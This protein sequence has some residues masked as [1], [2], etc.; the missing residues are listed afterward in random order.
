M[1]SAASTSRDTW[2]RSAALPVTEPTAVP[3]ALSAKEMT[4]TPTLCITPLVVRVLLAQRR[5]ALLETR[6][7]TMHWSLREA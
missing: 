5:L 7:I 6:A 2:S 4:V 1:A 3:P